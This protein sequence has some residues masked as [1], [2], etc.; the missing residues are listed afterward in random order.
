MAKFEV[1]V[2]EQVMERTRIGNLTKKRGPGELIVTDRRLVI[3]DSKSLGW[4]TY[5][6]G[7]LGGLVAA[8]QGTRIQ[9]DLKRGSLERLEVL[10]NRRLVLH[11]H[12]EG[13]AAQHVQVDIA[14]RWKD[15]LVLWNAGTAG[16]EALPTARVI[17]PR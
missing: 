15:R 17:E 11:T 6:F 4:A 1:Q 3:V 5:V 16:A 7:W 2:G 9:Y 10:G 13:Y 12:G 14:E 8:A